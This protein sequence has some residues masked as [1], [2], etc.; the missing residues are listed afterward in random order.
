MQDHQKTTKIDYRFLKIA[1]SLGYRNLGST[2]PN[3]SVG[4]VIVKNNHIIG[5]GN[6]AYKGRPHAEKI[7]LDQAK[8]N[9]IDSTVYLTL[10]PCSHFGKTNPCTSELIKAKVKRVVCPLKDPNP[11]VNG[12]GFELLR[13]HGI[14]VDNSPILLKELKDLN[15]GFITSIEKK[16]P[17]ITLK[18]AVS[19]NGKIATKENKSS[20]ISG[21]KSRTF[22]QMIRSNHDAILIG[23]KTA[24]W[25]NPR[26][27][28]RDHFKNLPQPVK[29]I[30]DKNLKLLDQ[31][32][33]SR[34]IPNNKIFLIHDVNLK[35]EKTKRLKV[36][37]INTLGVSTLENGYLDLIDLFKKLSKLGL[38][39]ILVEGGGK[40]A[41]S[42][43]ESKLV[44]K[45]ILFT[46]GII[47]DKDGVDGIHL[48]LSDATSLDD[49]DRYSLDKSIII[50]NDVAHFWNINN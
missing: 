30:L 29:I 15:E 13:K 45:L 7:A 18:L 50:G 31:I 33:L 36:K 22:V 17:F 21:E 19:L 9:A 40:L 12:K 3:P 11:K 43:I 10:E 41:T 37:G 44:D 48:N 38:T 28:L 34:S 25:D 46:A 20:W 26:L 2:W 14:V 8:S 23:T 49:C 32:D 1:I 39:R 4:C 24:F 35:K 6:T 5:V 16:R 42:L 27:N 47:L